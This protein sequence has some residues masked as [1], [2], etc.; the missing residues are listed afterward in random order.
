MSY[1]MHIIRPVDA[2]TLG[3]D[4]FRVNISGME[5]ICDVMRDLGMTCRTPGPTAAEFAAAPWGDDSAEGVARRTRVLSEHYG[6]CPGIPSH[7]FT[8]NDGWVVLPAEIRP[9]L[10]QY[11][12]AGGVVPERWDAVLAGSLAGTGGGSLWLDWV[13]FLVRA[14]DSGGFTVY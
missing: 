14:A 6:E 4:A 1:S 5:S 11:R 10:E 8:S 3:A 13:E 9:A 7:K 2:P 12:E